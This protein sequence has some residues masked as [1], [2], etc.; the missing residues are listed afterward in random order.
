MNGNGKVP[1][2]QSCRAAVLQEA[3]TLVAGWREN[4]VP[5]GRAIACAARKFHN[6][7]LR[8]GCRLA[9]STSSLRRHWDQWKRT[10]DASVFALKYKISERAKFDPILLRLVVEHCLQTGE[11]LSG[12]VES[13][14]RKGASISIRD[15][16]RVLSARTAVYLARSHKQLTAKRKKLEKRFLQS[17][18]RSNREF[19]KKQA[20]LQRRVVKEDE[21]LQRR[22]IRQR[23][24][25]QNKFLQADARAVREREKLQRKAL[26]D[27]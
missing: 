4:G 23:D 3:C 10:K 22:L 7:D 1:T 12:A 16:Y 9:L 13:L 8:G 11:S 15:I 21:K 24:L 27:L 26:R 2:W 25:L 6:A 17:V 14:R 18:D 19:L 5:L 20:T